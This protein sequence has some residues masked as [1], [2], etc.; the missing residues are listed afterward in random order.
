MVDTF[1]W[2][3]LTAELQ[4]IAL[5]YQ[6]K[7]KLEQCSNELWGEDLMLVVTA[8]FHLL[9]GCWWM[10]SWAPLGHVVLELPFCLKNNL[11]LKVSYQE[12][13]WDLHKLDLFHV[14]RGGG[15]GGETVQKKKLNFMNSRSGVI[16]FVSRSALYVITLRFSFPFNPI[17][18]NAYTSSPCVLRGNVLRG[19]IL[20]LPLLQSL[21]SWARWILYIL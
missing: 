16:C 7:Q 4:Y 6:A 2:I 21:L 11:L 1:R 20:M 14:C 12:K 17:R 15:E 3:W 13:F 9:V 5:Q 19:R 8:V 18:R 10:L